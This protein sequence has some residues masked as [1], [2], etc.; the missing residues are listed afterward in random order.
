[1]ILRRALREKCIDLHHLAESPL[2]S[3]RRFDS[4]SRQVFLVFIAAASCL[5]RFSNCLGSS[6]WL[7]SDCLPPLLLQSLS[8]ILLLLVLEVLPCWSEFREHEPWLIFYVQLNLLLRIRARLDKSSSSWFQ[9]RGIHCA[10][11]SILVSLACVA[12]S[13]TT[14]NG[15]SVV[16]GRFAKEPLRLLAVKSGARMTVVVV[17]S[18]STGPNETSASGDSKAPRD[19]FTLLAVLCFWKAR[20]PR[21]LPGLH[22]SF[23]VLLR[24][25]TSHRCAL[26]VC[27]GILSPR[28]VPRDPCRAAVAA[29]SF[30]AFLPVVREREQNVSR[31]RVRC[32]G[33]V[34]GVEG[35]QWWAKSQPYSSAPRTSAT[36]SNPSSKTC[37]GVERTSRRLVHQP[38]T[39]LRASL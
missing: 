36:R 31:E 37:V 1:M 30:R 8:G 35:T 23:P 29:P 38:S 39:L 7:A 5:P 22:S 27:F 14:A 11:I 26:F 34:S 21:V 12:S 6:I 25:P 32:V 9:S 16:T 19:A 28:L 3:V 18:F 10:P 20:E 15:Y 33:A 2:Q 13:M 4:P 17:A 24:P